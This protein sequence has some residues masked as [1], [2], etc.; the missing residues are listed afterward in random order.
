MTIADRKAMIDT[1]LDSLRPHWGLFQ[2]DIY[3]MVRH[4]SLRDAGGTP[5]CP[6]VT[7]YSDLLKKGDDAGEAAFVCNFHPMRAG[8]QLR[9][10]LVVIK[11]IT[12][13]ADRRTPLVADDAYAK[14]HRY[15]RD[16]MV[17]KLVEGMAA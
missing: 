1:F 8:T 14:M 15:A 3:G 2:V 5:C 4:T 7:G 16:Q 11:I 6:L 10:D 13:A 17:A 9:L 12:G